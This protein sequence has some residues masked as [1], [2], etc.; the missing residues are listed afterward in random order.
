[1]STVLESNLN[2]AEHVLNFP[3]MTIDLAKL[4]H[5][6]RAVADLCARH[7]VRAAAV[8]KC[9]CGDPEIA[10]ASVRGGAAWLA[11]SRLENLKR[12][13]ALDIPKLL[14]RLPM[15]SQAHNV[16]RYADL[17]LNSELATIR[18]LSS[19]ALE[20]GRVH[21]VILMVDL[22]D[23][24]EGISPSQV[25]S[26]VGEILALEGVALK[27]LG[28]NLTCFGGVLPGPENMAI[29]EGVVNEVEAA[30]GISLEIISG[31]NSSSVCMLERG[32]LPDCVNQLRF[33][34][35]ILFGTEFAYGGRIEG[36]YSDV[37]QLHAE[38]IELQEKLS[39]PYGDIGLDAFGK[40]PVFVDRG[41]RRRAILGIGKQD[42][43]LDTL[44]PLDSGVIVLGGSSDHLIVDVQDCP[45]PLEVGEVLSFNMHY[46]AVLSA[47]TSEYVTK[48][49]LK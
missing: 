36:T 25:V 46:T 30:W 43:I 21:G 11:D 6:T 20:A 44:K 24:R 31:G 37:F 19:A 42:V 4:E 45:R 34:E 9:Y 23:L 5:N 33:G 40:K 1:M 16:V 39:V 12:L 26:K 17:S 49:K 32:A 15:V 27:G 28:T 47:M 8:T 2:L 35:A 14:L 38:I 22:G 48:V 3:A 29:L 18:A 10:A 13:S 7:G 41:I